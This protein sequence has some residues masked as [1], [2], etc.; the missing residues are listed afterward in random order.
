MTDG[1]A[2]VPA[3]FTRETTIRR[4]A[5]GRWF[6][7]GALVEN[8]QV[9]KAFD[10]WIDRAE[11]GRYCLKNEV[12][13]A[14]V[15]IEGPPLFVND[16]QL[17]EGGAVWLLLSDE[18][19]E[20]LDPATLSMDG[21]GILHCRARDGTFEAKFTSTASFRLEP[22]LGEDDE[23]LFLEIEGKRVRPTERAA[24]PLT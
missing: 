3:H 10:R 17:G 11:D 8:P 4:D 19:R 18:R 22:L 15:E 13:W 2:N 7:D 6:H 1:E 16:V 20:K 5:L 12:N 24:D 23:G 14:Y 9:K 21:D